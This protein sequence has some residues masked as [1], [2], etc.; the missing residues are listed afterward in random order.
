MDF[1]GKVVIVT[2]ASRGLG[3]Q[4]ACE[5]AKRGANVAVND[6]RF[7]IMTCLSLL[8]IATNENNCIDGLDKNSH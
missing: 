2:G 7:K 3:R 6:L 4:Y 5:F 8:N 1:T